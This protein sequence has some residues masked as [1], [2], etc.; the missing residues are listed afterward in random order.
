LVAFNLL[1]ARKTNQLLRA[2]WIAARV[3][4]VPESVMI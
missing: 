2:A 4:T 1:D 3:F